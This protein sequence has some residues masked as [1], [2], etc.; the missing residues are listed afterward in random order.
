VWRPKNTTFQQE[1]IVGT[2]A[3]G[4]GGITVWG[5]FSLNCRIDLYVIDGT[6]TGQKYRDLI[7]RSLVVPHFD[8]HPLASRPIVVDDKYNQYSARLSARLSA[9]GG[10]RSTTLVIHDTGYESDRTVMGLSRT[11]SERTYPEVS[12]H[13]GIR[14]CFDSGMATVPS[15]QTETLDS[16]NEET[17]SGT[18]QD[19]RRLYSLLTLS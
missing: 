5:W 9:T 3:F 19:A 13:S 11:K 6:L 18:A 12:K 4:G 16:W 10:N 7:L 17:C 1:H 2:T 14:D 8:G 15:T